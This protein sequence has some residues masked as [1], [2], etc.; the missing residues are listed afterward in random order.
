MPAEMD[1]E[2]GE[3]E[4][5]GEEV[6]PETTLERQP[7]A[8]TS[9]TTSTSGV[10]EGKPNGQHISE[11]ASAVVGTRGGGGKGLSGRY[12]TTALTK[13][14]SFADLHQLGSIQAM[15]GIHLK[16]ALGRV[17]FSSGEGGMSPHD[18]SYTEALLERAAFV[19]AEMDAKIM[20]MFLSNAV[21]L[22][23]LNVLPQPLVRETLLARAKQLA[24]ETT[25]HGG[26]LMKKTLALWSGGLPAEN[27]PPALSNPF[28]HKQQAV[29]QGS[30]WP[31]GPNGM[32]MPP[33]GVA[34]PPFAPP[35]QHLTSRPP[36]SLGLDPQSQAGKS[37]GSSIKF[38]TGIP[39]LVELMTRVHDF[40]HLHVN[41]ALAALKKL[42]PNGGPVQDAAQHHI[43]VTIMLR[44]GEVAGDYTAAYLT[45]VLNSLLVLGVPPPPPVL[46]S[47]LARV[48]VVMAEFSEQQAREV[49]RAAAAWGVE[50]GVE[51]HTLHL[52]PETPNPQPSTLNPQP[53]T[54]QS[55]PATLTPHPS[56]PNP[57]SSTLNP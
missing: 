20:T 47:L 23:P 42:V 32:G 19:A 24:I 41:V 15:N 21:R 33:N 1:V 56:H 2:E 57:Q 28:Q 30:G 34:G 6:P 14:S 49:L 39:S 17:L 45:Q 29:P 22:A 51:V 18:R 26:E 11:K 35:P 52:K 55:Q 40:N 27:R 5:E 3:L 44:A 36:P 43:A 9:A 13:C 38:C 25:P 10:G 37:L 7:S 53:S 50:P 12:L 54:L 46:A 8:T 48:R 4:G 16:V 31:G